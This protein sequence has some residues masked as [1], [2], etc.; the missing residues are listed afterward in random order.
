MKTK[1]IV[2]PYNW[3]SHSL[4]SSKYHQRIV[5]SRRV[6]NRQKEKRVKDKEV[7]HENINNSN[8]FTCVNYYL[9]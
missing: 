5:K 7:F 6:Y 3:V 4:M 1:M 8:I 2:I 9:V